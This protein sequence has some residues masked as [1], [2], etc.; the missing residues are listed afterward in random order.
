MSPIVARFSRSGLQKTRIRKAKQLGRLPALSAVAL[1]FERAPQIDSSP[2]AFVLEVEVRHRR[3]GARDGRKALF[4]EGLG[5]RVLFKA[6]E[7]GSFGSDREFELP[8]ICREPSVDLFGP[9]HRH[10]EGRLQEF[11][12]HERLHFIW[13]IEAVGVEVKQI[14]ASA[15]NG[16]DVEAGAGHGLLDAPCH[17]QTFDEHGFSSS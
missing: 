2:F 14:S 10:A 9:F 8:A 12:D 16:K 3:F 15:V 4:F 17:G 7:M 13:R 5:S 11:F 6:N 1:L